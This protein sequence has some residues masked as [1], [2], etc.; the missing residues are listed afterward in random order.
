MSDRDYAKSTLRPA[1]LTDPTIPPPIGC[2]K[3]PYIPSPLLCPFSDLHLAVLARMPPTE[4][5]FPPN[6]LG[7]PSR[8][9]ATG[10]NME[11]VANFVRFQHLSNSK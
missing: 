11:P 2:S 10:P 7:P 1:T 6:P 5:P 3:N 8:R 4:K 9:T